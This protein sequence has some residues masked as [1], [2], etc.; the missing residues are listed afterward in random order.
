L[1][2][3]AKVESNMSI[4]PKL[5]GTVQRELRG[6]EN[7]LKQ[8][9]RDKETDR[10]GTDTWIWTQAEQGHYDPTIISPSS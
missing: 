2:L 9:G 3:Y 7:R 8:T 10:T 6:V 1:Y 4:K 5:K